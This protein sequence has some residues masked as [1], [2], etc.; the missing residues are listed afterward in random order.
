MHRRLG[1]FLLYLLSLTCYCQTIDK[2]NKKIK[3]SNPSL[4]ARRLA[5][6]QVRTLFQAKTGTW[7][8]MDFEAYEWEH[9][10]ITE[11][12]W[13]KLTWDAEGNEIQERGHAIIKE[14]RHLTNGRWVPE[15]R[16][17]SI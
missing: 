10:T 15:H 7:L 1:Y 11:F 8:A 16:D 4:T 6:E 13:S 14:H 5:F 3:G 2:L 12:G 17:V 9:K